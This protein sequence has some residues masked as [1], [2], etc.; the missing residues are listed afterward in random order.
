MRNVIY[1][2]ALLWCYSRTHISVGCLALTHLH[3][4]CTL[5]LF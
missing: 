2:R 5:A 4:T 3:I 1:E